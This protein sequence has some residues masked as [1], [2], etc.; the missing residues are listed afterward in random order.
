MLAALAAQVGDL[1]AGIGF[2]EYLS[3]ETICV[4]VNRLFFMVVG[5]SPATLILYF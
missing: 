3:I 1:H 5:V 2:L 4:S